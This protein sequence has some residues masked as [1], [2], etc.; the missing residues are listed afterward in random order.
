MQNRS[1]FVLY[2]EYDQHLELLT[3]EEC[4][5]L[6]RAIMQ[7]A[8]TGESPDLVGAERMAFSFIR[9]Q[10]E[11]DNERYEETRKK[12]SEA[13]KLGGRPQKAEKANAFTEKQTKAKK[14]VDVYVD[15]DVDG[16]VKDLTP[17][18]PE[19]AD[20]GESLTVETA[21]GAADAADHST[22]PQEPQYFPEFWKAYPNKVG[23][24]AARKIWAKRKPDR[25]LLEVMLAAIAAQKNS[26]QWQ[27]DGGQYIPNPATWLN[28]ERWEDEP[29]GPGQS[30]P[31]ALGDLDFLLEGGD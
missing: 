14:G 21:Q 25:A 3:D 18:P 29:N 7:Y 22:T 11:R 6:F 17:I 24:G 13:G 30:K 4:G 28:Q 2:T 20:A 15:V 10:M 8:A 19:G 23:K 1:S 9:A 5:R 31:A 27:R 12:R 16:D 26:S